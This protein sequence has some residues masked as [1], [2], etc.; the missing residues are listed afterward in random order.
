MEDLPLL[1]GTM[2]FPVL[3]K[4]VRLILEPILTWLLQRE[5]K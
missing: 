2:V 4:A 5:K 3:I 1:P